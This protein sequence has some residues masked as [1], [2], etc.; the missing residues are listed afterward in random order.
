MK[1]KIGVFSFTSCEGCQL[2]ILNLEDEFM[3]LI[4]YIE[5]VNFREAISEKGED[6][7]IAFVEG[8]ITRESEIAE[9]KNIRER[10]KILIALGTCSH[11]GGINVLKN[12]HPQDSWLPSVY[13]RKDLFTDTIRTKR[14]KD[15]VPVDL[16]IPGCPIDKGEFL[17]FVQALLLRI[18]PVLPNYPVCVEC[19]TK[20]NVCLVEEGKWCLGSVTRAGCGAICPTYRDSC[21]GCRGL[22]SEPNI[23]SLCNILMEKGLTKEDV[24]DK[25][26]IFNGLETINI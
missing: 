25:F 15:V 16:V 13:G 17:R 18:K 9:L 22:V 26:N 8:S 5:F 14:I 6:Y 4:D 3:T 23:E 1:P 2:Q 19:R 20:G 12:F 24:R 7:E 21:S 10:A 11:L